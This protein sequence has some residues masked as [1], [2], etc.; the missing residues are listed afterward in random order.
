MASGNS[1]MREVFDNG[2]ALQMP[3]GTNPLTVA[4]DVISV[5]ESS[6]DRN[7]RTRYIFLAVSGVVQVVICLAFNLYGKIVPH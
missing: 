3:N 7:T 2:T 5:I 4:A 6:D 1:E